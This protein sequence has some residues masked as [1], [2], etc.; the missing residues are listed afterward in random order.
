[1]AGG[2]IN[3]PTQTKK[4]LLIFRLRPDLLFS[5]LFS[6]VCFTTFFWIKSSF[7]LFYVEVV[8]KQDVWFLEA[9][10]VFVGENKTIRI[11]TNYQGMNWDEGKLTVWRLDQCSASQTFKY[12]V[13]LVHKK[14][15]ADSLEI[16][17]LFKE[18]LKEPF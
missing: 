3:P 12:W 14:N 5:R 8:A 16:Q 15:F 10:K 2:D 7:F 11:I 4:F 17:K 18:P 9:S 6:L 13:T 1:M